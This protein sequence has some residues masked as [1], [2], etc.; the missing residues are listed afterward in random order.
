MINCYV[1]FFYIYIYQKFI[2]ITTT[3]L[4]LVWYC[5]VV[6]FL[7]NLIFFIFLN[8]FDMLI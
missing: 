8:Y 2:L 3:L 4:S 7:K 1:R 6:V 5:G